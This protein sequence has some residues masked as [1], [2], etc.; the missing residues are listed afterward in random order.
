MATA[1]LLEY[2]ATGYC[3]VS[4]S[5]GWLFD[6]DPLRRLAAKKGPGR[7]AIWLIVVAPPIGRMVRRNYATLRDVLGWTDPAACERAAQWLL[8]DWRRA[9]E[10]GA[11][12]RPFPLP[13]SPLQ[14]WQFE[15]GG[16]QGCLVVDPS[17]AAGFPVQGARRRHVTDVHLRRLAWYRHNR[18]MTLAVVGSR[19][20][21]GVYLARRLRSLRI[22]PV[23]LTH[24]DDLGGLRQSFSRLWTEAAKNS[25]R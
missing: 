9:D 3:V 1:T 5:G 11:N 7:M 18:H 16:R 23:A 15:S 2:A 22:T 17:T 6:D 14:I 19:V 12:G 10:F 4:E 20:I 21:G 25:G 8:G 24:G 13:T